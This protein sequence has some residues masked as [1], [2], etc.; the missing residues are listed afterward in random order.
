[1]NS[2][3]NLTVLDVS[4]NKLEYFPL[5]MQD[6]VSNPK[7]VIWLSCNQSDPMQFHKAVHETSGLTTRKIDVLTCAL[8]PQEKEQFFTNT[9]ERNFSGNGFQN[10]NNRTFGNHQI[11]Q[12]FTT[13]EQ[14][15]TDDDNEF[16]HKPLVRFG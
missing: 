3:L 4:S 11:N 6:L 1:M 13:T 8:L 15:T 10:N 16:I 14:G 7:L 12:Y 2:L 5:G 9:F